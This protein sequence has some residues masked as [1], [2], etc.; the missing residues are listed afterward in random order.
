[1][2]V[3]VAPCAI[4]GATFYCLRGC[5]LEERIYRERPTTDRGRRRF[6]CSRQT[7]E[8]SRPGDRPSAHQRLFVS[9]F[10][11]ALRSIAGSDPVVFTCSTTHL[12]R[13]IETTLFLLTHVVPSVFV[14]VCSHARLSYSLPSAILTCFPV[15][16]RPTRSPNS[17]LLAFLIPW[18]K[19]PVVL[20]DFYAS[21]RI[22]STSLVNPT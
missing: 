22:S 10:C 20:P 14:C 1:M 3:T 9:G 8:C 17:S 5:H 21:A 12:R 15:V 18:F 16:S 19:T 13:L 6:P 7:P 4:K 11:E 2:L